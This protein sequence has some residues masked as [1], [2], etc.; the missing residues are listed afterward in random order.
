MSTISVRLTSGRI[1]HYQ[2]EANG[3]EWLY[4]VSRPEDGSLAIMG[5][6]APK[7]TVAYAPGTWECVIEE[8]SG[9]PPEPDH[10]PYAC[11]ICGG[12][13]MPKAH[14]QGDRL[15]STCMS[16]RSESQIAPAEP[17]PKPED[18][19]WLDKP[20]G[21]GIWLYIE[22]DGDSGAAAAFAADSL[23]FAYCHAGAAAGLKDFPAGTRWHLLASMS[24]I[25]GLRED[26]QKSR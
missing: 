26:I 9:A 14:A 25:D 12:I 1:D 13:I 10:D 7:S 21:A 15:C 20:D 22:P 5:L 19:E 2:V 3:S 18:S 8:A 16:R 11:P 17:A 24:S 4:L 6:L 23:D